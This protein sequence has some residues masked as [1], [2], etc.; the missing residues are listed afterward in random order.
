VVSKYSGIEAYYEEVGKRLAAK[1]HEVTVYCRTY[2]TPALEDYLGLRLVRLPTIRT[3]HWETLIHTFLSTLHVLRSNCDIVHYHALGPALFSFIP[4]LFG[5]KT[6]V[7]VQGLDWQR[8]KWGRFAS[9]V[10]RLGEKASLRFPSST[11]VVSRTLSEHYLAHYQASTIYI[12]NGTVIRQRR[13]AQKLAEWGLRPDGYI[14]FLGRFSPEKNCHLLLKAHEQIETSVKLVMAGGSSY[15]T[16]YE[17]ELRKHAGD[18]V[19]L[20]DYVSGEALEELLSNAM[21]FVLPSDMEGL[22]LALLDAMGA[23]V[24]ALTSDIAENRELVDHGGFTFRRNDVNDLERMLRLLLSEDRVRKDAA[25][26]G[27][28]YVRQNYLWE[29]ITEQIEKVYLDLAGLLVNHRSG[30]PSTSTPDQQPQ[31]H[32]A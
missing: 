24:C 31:D 13:P 29:T 14:L 1:G 25:L 11:M 8:R 28:E 9:A 20:L 16:A 7:T 23:G 26:K 6:V 10:L 3:K 15:S 4:R 18:R 17:N 19:V 27:Q 22:S 2:F 12:P 5:K 21:L 30:Q 32:A